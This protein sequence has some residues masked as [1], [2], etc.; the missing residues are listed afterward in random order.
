M[1]DD[2]SYDVEEDERESDIFRF[3]PAKMAA[4]AAIGL[5]AV[6]GLSALGLHS[7]SKRESSPRPASSQVYYDSL[8]NKVEVTAKSGDTLSGLMNK[9]SGCYPKGNA[10]YQWQ[11]DNDTTTQNISFGKEYIFRTTNTTSKTSN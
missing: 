5:A 7:C 3:N 8:T 10:L 11:V 9:Y 6:I 2:Y 1:T 4:G